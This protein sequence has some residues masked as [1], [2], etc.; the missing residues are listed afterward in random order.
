[1]HRIVW[2]IR[3]EI[4]QLRRNPATLRLMFIMPAMQLILLGY[5]VTFDIRNLPVL[6]VDLDRSPEGREL[7]DRIGSTEY[8]DIRYLA[9]D[10][11]DIDRYLDR[12]RASVA[13]VIPRGFGR[14]LRAGRSP[15]LAAIFDGSDPNTATVAMGYLSAI[16]GRFSSDM[17]SPGPAGAFGGGLL[18]E[19][20]RVEF[21]EEL[22]SNVFLIPG[23]IGLILMIVT[24]VLTSVSV[25]REK[26]LGTI[27]QIMATPVRSHE[28][29][30]G[31]IIPFVVIGFIDI[32]M[33]IAIGR[34]WFGVPVRGSLPLLAGFCFC[35]LL[36]TL[37]IGLF[38]STISRTQQQ[39]MLTAFFF[40]P[41][42][43]V[44]SG[45]IFPIESMPRAIQYITYLIPLRYFLVI[46]RGIFLKGVGLDA[47]WREGLV[48]LLLG[49][50]ALS[51]SILR[52]RRRLV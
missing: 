14:D 41:P 48:L 34:F 19:K 3:K 16:V 5:A 23:L 47:I 50:G 33:V 26:E 1:M 22:E 29:L 32:S 28:L 4:K 13:V 12:N 18:G 20:L 38:V 43:I 36:T 8:F 45:L 49:L 39:A 40:I 31:K 17:A 30:L 35:F 10:M 21:N 42:N 27:E 46:V 2:I 51:L 11:R 44:L 9:D 37:G 15:E 25:V 7:V 6:V 52:F 24:M